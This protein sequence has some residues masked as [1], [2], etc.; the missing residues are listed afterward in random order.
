MTQRTTTLGYD[1]ALA[2][3]EWLSERISVKPEVAMILGSGLGG[4]ADDLTDATAFDYAD[5]PN[6]PTSTVVGH[7]G[8][9]VFGRLGDR[10]VVAMRGRFHYYEGWD[11]D[12]VTFPVRVFSLLGCTSLA[13]TNS[14][15]GVNPDFSPGDLML[16][17]DHINFTG[18]N[19]LRGANDA[20]FGTRFPDMTEAYD[21]ELRRR[22]I[23]TA[24]ELE[25]PLHIGVY[26]GVQGP[27]YETPAE[28]GMMRRMGA[29][30]VGMSTVPEVIVAN[31]LG[32]RVLGMSCI[33]NLAAGYSS[34]EL[35]HDEVTENAAIARAAFTKLL[36]HSIAVIDGDE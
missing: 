4:I 27:S 12:Q 1:E 18:V 8:Q 13:V 26:I 28:I 14:A 2:T 9:L 22:V 15:G 33:T 17:R 34:Q 5:I 35:T 23:E 7:A 3:A 30:A 24:R 20:R 16:I 32:L 6:F 19:P 10:P 36:V 21:F 11:L 29:D 25:I 31:H